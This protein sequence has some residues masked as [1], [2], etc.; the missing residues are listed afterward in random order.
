M[1]NSI[2]KSCLFAIFVLANSSLSFAAEINPFLQYT[3]EKIEHTNTFHPSQK[4]LL[5]PKGNRSAYIPEFP[6]NTKMRLAL[7]TGNINFFSDQSRTEIAAELAK[8]RIPEIMDRL[9]KEKL[10]DEAIR[11]SQIFNI[12]PL[13]VIGPVVGEFVFNG[14]LDQALQ[15]IKARND[16]MKSRRDQETHPDILKMSSRMSEIVDHPSI[17]DCLNSQ[18][19]NYWKWRCVL[20]YSSQ[21]SGNNS[22]ADL[23]QGFYQFNKDRNGKTASFGTFGIGQ[24]QPYLMWSV[25]DLVSKKM[26]TKK[27]E[28]TDLETP[29]EIIFDNKQMLSY[30]AA[31]S[32]N[33]IQIYKL[34]AGVDI[35]QNPGLVVTLYNV[36]D[37][38]IR[39]YNL[40]QQRNADPNNFY[41][42]ENY[43]GWFINR[44]ETQ[45]RSYLR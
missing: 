35:G 30:I 13:L 4:V 1:N 9:K 14:F 7:F 18:I 40:A 38:F 16:Y 28:V 27:F 15:N 36:G 24:M 29:F 41:P 39:A 42:Q 12:D 11:V 34:I 26:K 37:E 23:L 25:N 31:I 22:N 32:Y 17:R 10:I 20:F 33:S 2:L 44:Y 5:A 3:P 43:M 6:T 45:I 21:T 8:K 19:S